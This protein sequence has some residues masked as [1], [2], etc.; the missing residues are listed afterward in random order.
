MKVTKKKWRIELTEITC[1]E[2]AAIKLALKRLEQNENEIIE[3]REEARKIRT[4]I[5]KI[6]I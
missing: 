5:E 2:I 1:V 6:K 3:W 4:E